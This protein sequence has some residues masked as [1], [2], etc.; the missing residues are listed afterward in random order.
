MVSAA[1][2]VWEKAVGCP[3]ALVLTGPLS[4]LWGCR[5]CGGRWVFE[6]RS[7]HGASDLPFS[8]LCLGSFQ[9]YLV[10]ARVRIGKIVE[11]ILKTGLRDG[12]VGGNMIF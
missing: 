11:G 1:E 10:L 3:F 4:W 6:G 7:H 9:V 12:A 2:P 8:V 5:F